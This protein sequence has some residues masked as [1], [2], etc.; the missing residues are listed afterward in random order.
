MI[1]NYFL[2]WTRFFDYFK[3]KH[4]PSAGKTVE[5]FS[6]PA[7][8]SKGAFGVSA[9]KG[10]SFKQKSFRIYLHCEDNDGQ[11]WYN[12]MNNGTGGLLVDKKDN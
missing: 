9:P 6:M 8:N 11:Q 4:Q 3:K 10:N 2:K 12:E 1:F 7:L 5:S